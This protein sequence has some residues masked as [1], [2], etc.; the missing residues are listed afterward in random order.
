M[1]VPQAPPNIAADRLHTYIAAPL[2][3]FASSLDELQCLVHTLVS[4][5]NG[6]PVS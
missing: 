5:I 2:Q 4:D 3:P 6:L 1:E